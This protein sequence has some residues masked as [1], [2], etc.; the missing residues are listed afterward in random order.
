VQSEKVRKDVRNRDMKCR[1]TGMKIHSRNRGANFKGFH[2][3]HIYPLAY[4]PNVSLI[5]LCRLRFVNS[6]QASQNIA[7]TDVETLKLVETHK[8]ADKP[9]NALV[10]RADAHDLFDDYQ[11]GY[12]PEKV[13]LHKKKRVFAS[14]N[15]MKGL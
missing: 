10:M 11:F 5:L 8:L 4:V 9:Y 3:A 1:V 2:V 12:V 6:I 14:V 7:H 15:W 13:S